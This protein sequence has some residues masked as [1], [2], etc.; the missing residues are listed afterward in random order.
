MSKILITGASGQ[1][2]RQVVFNALKKVEANQIA[3]LVRNASSV[4]D[5]ADLGI[6]IRLGDYHQPETLSTALNGISKLLLISSND[7]NNRLGQHKNV[8]DAAKNAGVKHI[9]YTG[10]SLKDIQHSPLKPLLGDHFL[11]E[12]YIKNLGFTYTFLQNSLYAE[13]I[14]MFIGENVLE[15]GIYFP[16]GDGKVPFVLR[17][18]LAEA[19]ANIL[20]EAHHE[21]KTYQLTSSTSFSFKE[22]ALTLSE[23]SGKE[24]LYI[25]PEPHEYENMLKQIGLPEH[26]ITMSSLFAAG[27]KNNDLNDIHIDLKTFLS[28]EEKDLKTY[29]KDFYHL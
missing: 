14:P 17:S 12:D 25:S 3:V 20:T 8:I 22:I 11:T 10:V 19:T 2:G 16:A 6:E 13:V 23:L 7:F 27:I 26:I 18:D 5:L 28:S 1:L 9:F 21:N 15:T 24:I 29:L 4:Q